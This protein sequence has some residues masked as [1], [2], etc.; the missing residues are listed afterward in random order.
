MVTFT[1]NTAIMCGGAAQFEKSNIVFM[2]NSSTLFIGNVA[3]IAGE[4]IF[5]LENCNIKLTQYSKM[6][7]FNNNVAEG[8]GGAMA[9]HDKN[10]I[11]IEGNSMVAFENKL[12]VHYLKTRHS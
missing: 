5:T 7:F 1:N 10:V 3:N 11:T 8:H 4:A 2:E 9:I 12:T 6:L